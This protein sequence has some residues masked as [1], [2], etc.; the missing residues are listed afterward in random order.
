MSCSLLQKV[1]IVEV[2]KSFAYRVINAAQ[3]GKRVE[4]KREGFVVWGI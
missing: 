4:R 2:S 1:N 3:P